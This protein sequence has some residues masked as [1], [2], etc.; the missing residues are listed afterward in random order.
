M[1]DKQA[2]ANCKYAEIRTM[3]GSVPVDW[4]CKWRPGKKLTRHTLACLQW[5][6]RATCPMTKDAVKKVGL[7]VRQVGAFCADGCSVECQKMFGE[8]IIKKGRKEA[9]E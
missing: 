3:I 4:S 7:T 1:S 6:A 8:Y 5:E 2:C 9:A